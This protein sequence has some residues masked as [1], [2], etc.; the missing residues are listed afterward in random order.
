M[1]KN[2][3]NS[4][5]RGHEDCFLQIQTVPKMSARSGIVGKN[6]PHL[7]P[8]Q[9]IFS[10][11]QTKQKMNKISLFSLVGQCTLFTW[12]STFADVSNIPWRCLQAGA[13]L[14][15]LHVKN[16][17][18]PY[19]VWIAERVAYWLTKENWQKILK[20]CIFPAYGKKIWR[21]PKKGREGFLH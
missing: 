2:T 8:P 4:T 3:W 20:F 16:Y 19:Q 1:E 15:A 12:F 21:G 9:V 10:I 7:G 11:D 14:M 18:Q 6:P 13:G 5:K 17:N